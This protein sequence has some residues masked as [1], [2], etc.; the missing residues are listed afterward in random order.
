MAPHSTNQMPFV[1]YS[2]TGASG[3][4]TTWSLYTVEVG[5]TAVWNPASPRV[6][7]FQTRSIQH[8]LRVRAT[9][10]AAAVHLHLRIH[11]NHGPAARRA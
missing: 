1:T 2:P 8:A 3:P 5:S 4:S 10:P 6:D 7:A 9:H 11:V